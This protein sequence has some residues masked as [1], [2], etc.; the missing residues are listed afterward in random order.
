MKR[1]IS[2]S[3][4]LAIF[5]CSFFVGCVNDG[6][7]KI[8][9]CEVTHSIFYAPLYVAINNGYFDEYDIKIELTNGGGADKVMTAIA[10]K[11]AD[12]GLLGPEATIYC[13]AQGQRDYPLIF[14]QLT[15][16]DGSF[17][18]SKTNDAN[19]RW[20]DLRGK[21]VLAGRAGGVPA[22]TMQFVVNNA[23]LDEK[24]D[25]DF[26]TEVAF[27]MMGPVFEA[28]ETVDY[29][30]LFEP[31][32]SEFVAAG[33]GYIVASVGEASGEIPYTAFSASKSYLENNGDLIR[34]FLRAVKKGYDYLVQNSGDEVAPS[35]LPS[36]SGT[37]LSSIATA[38]ESYKRI[39]A[40]KGDLFFTEQ[41]Y[42]KLQEVMA[43]A[44]YLESEVSFAEAVDNS[45]VEAI[46]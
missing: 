42:A 24:T 36:F 17:L 29:T 22:M 40:W 1:F 7:T 30:T 3:F 23:G 21:K 10:S 4:V 46:S 27:N 26:N 31:T 33:K 25:L 45:F 44:G 12:I 13:Q 11:S 6:K 38:I 18:V 39:D 28:D 16:R 9:L 35:L 14:G 5:V 20:E 41:A 37:S 8:R 43:N 2:L 34:N 19:F 32:A 15:K